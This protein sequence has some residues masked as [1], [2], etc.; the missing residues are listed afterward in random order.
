MNGNLDIHPKVAGSTLAGSV[1]ILIIWILSL[2]GIPVP[3]V[4]DGAL[5][6]VLTSLGGWLAPAGYPPASP[7]A[8]PD[9]AA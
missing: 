7:P 2:V 5:V 4:A 3:D 6:I 1:A 9:P 8:P